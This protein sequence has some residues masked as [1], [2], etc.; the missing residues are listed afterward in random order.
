[1][2]QGH[3]VMIDD[4]TFNFNKHNDEFNEYKK[5]AHLKRM[6]TVSNRAGCKQL[7]GQWDNKH[8]VCILH[9]HSPG[10]G[11]MFGVTAPIF[12]G[13][14][15][16]MLGEIPPYYAGDESEYGAMIQGCWLHSMEIPNA[17]TPCD[18]FYEEKFKWDGDEGRIGFT[19]TYEQAREKALTMARDIL[20]GDAHKHN[21]VYYDKN[22]DFHKYPQNRD[23]TVSFE[24]SSGCGFMP[25]GPDFNKPAVFKIR[26]H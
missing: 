13:Y 9:E 11:A 17:W 4:D 16:W 5:W 7:E 23:D 2:S 12:G 1:M 3:A 21:L 25:V 15:E 26:G 10:R 6:H 18:S 22:H 19:K 14:M 8:D 20:E 24:P